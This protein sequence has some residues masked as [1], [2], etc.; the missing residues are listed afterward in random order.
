MKSAITHFQMILVKAA[1][2]AHTRNVSRPLPFIRANLLI[3]CFLLPSLVLVGQEKENKEADSLLNIGNQMINSLMFDS[4]LHYQKKAAALYLEDSAMHNYYISLIKQAYSLNNGG[5]PEASMDILKGLEEKF[6]DSQHDLLSEVYRHIAMISEKAGDLEEAIRIY[7]QAFDVFQ[8]D[9]TVKSKEELASL[10]LSIGVSYALSTRFFKAKSAWE[11]T[12]FLLDSLGMKD[13]YYTR[14]LTNLATVNM[15]MGLIDKSLDLFLEVRDLQVEML[16]TTRHPQ[17]IYLY[18]NLGNAYSRQ[19]LFERAIEYCGLSMSLLKSVD[20]NHPLIIDQS[21]SLARDLGRLTRNT[22]AYDYLNDATARSI[23]T[24]GPNDFM[25][26]KC[27]NGMGGYFLDIDNFEEALGYL[28]KSKAILETSNVN[29]ASLLPRLYYNLGQ[30][31]VGTGKEELGLDYMVRGAKMLSEFTNGKSNDLSEIYVRISDAYSN[32]ERFDEALTYS[33]MALTATIGGFNSLNTDENPEIANPLGERVLYLA[34]LSKV[35]SLEKLSQQEN[36]LERLKQAQDIFNLIW[37]V[38]TAVAQESNV[39]GDQFDLQKSKSSVNS[40]GVRI[41]SRLYELTGDEAYIHFIHE[42]MERDKSNLLLSNMVDLESFESMG[43]PDSLRKE[44]ATIAQTIAYLESQ[45]S[46]P[47]GNKQRTDSTQLTF[48]K[49]NLVDW[50]YK[51]D[52]LNKYI[53]SEFP[54]FY[55]LRW[56]PS[57][58]GITETQQK[59]L[60]QG[61]LMLLYYLSDSTLVTLEVEKD[62]VDFRTEQV[63]QQFYDEIENFSAYCRN[64]SVKPEKYLESSSFLMEKLGLDAERL[65]SYEKLKIVPSGVLGLLP[66]DALVANTDVNP[67]GFGEMEFLV[68]HIPLVYANSASLLHLQTRSM[69]R[70]N[71]R[72]LAFAPSFMKAGGATRSLDTVRAGLSNLAWTKREV[73]D[74]SQYFETEKYLGDQATEEA[75]RQLVNDFGVIHVASH[76]LIN[77]EAPLYSKLVFS[78]EMT[79]SLNDGFVNTRELFAMQIPAKMVVLSACNTGSGD[80]ATGEGII[81]LANGFFYAGSRSVVMTLWQANDQSSAQ[82]MNGFYMNLSEGMDKSMAL[83]QSK[84]DY[85]KSSDALQSHPYFWAHFVVNGDDTPLIRAGLPGFWWFLLFIPVAFILI[86]RFRRQSAG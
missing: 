24:F 42:S 74:L 66:F 64:P 57:I 30:A 52:E 59:L 38:S 25:T 35:N 26:A 68:E 43:L 29:D 53:E 6:V 15:E 23:K 31:Y 51:E 2:P 34:L 17:L 33:Q 32:A 83:R 50:R 65:G 18:Y 85:L 58:T 79:D 49:A 13:D 61:E 19:E 7:K 70:R 27:Y 9:N 84:M 28:L 54:E 40:I 1:F 4:A 77:D 73:E 62:K 46:D 82:V 14:A 45:V 8:D 78:S 48:Y 21:L 37:R 16:G 72:V 10:N 71:D 22:E 20:P 47:D 75:F 11:K 41:G 36:E 56:S 76:G 12:V 69:E 81:S 55:N 67:T 86:S 63:S 44:K 5:K 80:I 60:K 3:L 39:I